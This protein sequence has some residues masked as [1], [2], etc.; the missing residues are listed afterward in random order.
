MS[1]RRLLTL[2]SW[3]IR[4]KKVMFFVVGHFGFLKH[5]DR[6]SRDPKRIILSSFKPDFLA[7][8]RRRETPL[9]GEYQG[10]KI[11]FPSEN[12]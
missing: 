9:N 12:G 2:D 4:A 11:D 1:H 10:P 5:K 8:D 6:K 3:M 7:G